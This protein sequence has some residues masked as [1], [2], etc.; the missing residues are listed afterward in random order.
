MFRGKKRRLV[1]GILLFELVLAL[2]LM[3]SSG[4]IIPT[5]PA[6]RSYTVRGVDVSHHQGKINWEKIAGQGMDFAFI[7]AT[8]GKSFKD[9]NFEQN[10]AQAREHLTAGAYHFLSFDVSGEEQA[11]NFIES[12][13]VV[14]GMLPPVVDVELYGDYR[15]NPPSRHQVAQI[16]EPMLKALEAHYGVMPIL[17][18]TSRSYHRYIDDKFEQYP[19]WIRGVYRKP[20]QDFDF[21]QYTDRGTLKGHTGRERFIDL[22]VFDGSEAELEKLLIQ[23]P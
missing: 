12:V 23:R 3:V 21:W 16:L 13:P 22:N 18:A 19:L 10:F 11:R 14:S 5:E 8:E 4:L 20:G 2:F 6:A 17:Y 7:K 1:V 15:F 9:P